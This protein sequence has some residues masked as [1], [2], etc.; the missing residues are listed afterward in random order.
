MKKALILFGVLMFFCSVSW[1]NSFE[2]FEKMLLANCGGCEKCCQSECED[3]K[4]ESSSNEQKH[5]KESKN[6]CNSLEIDDDEYF[7]Y[8]QCFFDKQYRNLKRTLCLTKRQ[9]ECIDSLYKNFKADMDNIHS[10]YRSSRED[11]LI[12]MD[13]NCSSLKEKKHRLREIKREAK[14]KTKD[15]KEEIKEY[16]CKKQISEFKHFQ[17]IEKR[18]IKKLAKYCTVYKFPCSGCCVK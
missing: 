14:E 6:S 10:R 17:K 1:A 5:C 18:K 16:L 4:K 12:A 15:F 7:V 3:C 8:N 11:L 13:S 9:E 2:N